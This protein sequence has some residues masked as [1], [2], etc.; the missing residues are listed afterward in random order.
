MHAWKEVLLSAFLFSNQ[1]VQEI[2][3]LLIWGKRVSVYG[4]IENTKHIYIH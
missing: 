2:S 1:V 4:L 3:F